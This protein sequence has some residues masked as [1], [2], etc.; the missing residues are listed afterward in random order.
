MNMEEYF[1]RLQRMAESQKDQSLLK[2]VRLQAEQKN[3]SRR[4]A[5]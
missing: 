2:Q 5:K 4:S 1:D 3:K